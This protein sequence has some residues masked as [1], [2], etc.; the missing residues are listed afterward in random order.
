MLCAEITIYLRFDKGDFYDYDNNVD[1]K[2]IT[3][4]F[5]RKRSRKKINV[6]VKKFNT[7][8]LERE[9]GKDGLFWMWDNNVW[10]HLLMMPLYL[11]TKEK[12]KKNSPHCSRL[13]VRIHNR[14]KSDLS[15][16]IFI[17]SASQLYF[18]Y[19]TFVI[20]KN[21]PSQSVFTDFRLA[22]CL[23]INN[24]PINR[25]FPIV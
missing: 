8:I 17:S 9:R 6:I 12:Y 22:F 10:T 13:P 21:F 18:I 2:L 1:Q 23:N 16:H 5:Y 7:T 19:Q 15:C 25:Y 11:V 14:K 3:L 24:N 20:I 4:Y